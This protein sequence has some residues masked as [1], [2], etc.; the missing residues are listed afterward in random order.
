MTPR[1]KLL[2]GD[3]AV[4]RGAWEAGV[5]V[6]AAY[7][8][9]PSTEILENIARYDGIYAEW[10]PNEK[11][12]LEVAGNA[13]IAGVR[14]L[15]AMKHV[16]LNVASDP[17]MTL[18]YTGIGRGFVVACADDPGMHSSQNEQD[19]R[20]Y[21]RFA[22]VPM[23]EPGDSDEAL[24]MTKAAFELSE[25]FDTPVLLRMTTRVCHGKSPVT[26]GERAEVETK[27]FV[28]NPQKYVMI[29]GH[30]RKRHVI[31]EERA[32]KLAE[33]SE[34]S[35]FNRAIEGTNGIGI[36]TSGIAAQYAREVMPDAGFLILGMTWPLP[37]RM[38]RE[39][40]A[41][42][43]TLYV[44]EELEPYLEEQIRAM[45]I[46]VTGKEKF[47]RCGE[48]TPDLVRTGLTGTKPA[49]SR[50]PKDL[51]IPMRPPVLCPGCPHRGFFHIVNKNKLHV[52]GDVGCYTLSVLPPLSA[53]DTCICMGASISGAIGFAKAFEDQPGKK[54]VAALGDSTFMHSGLTGLMDT[55]YNKANVITCV[56]DNR[57]TAMT[58]HQE[59][60]GTGFT[61][62]GEP[63]HRTDIAEV[64]RAL[65]VKHVYE[66]DPYDLAETDRIMKT[67]LEAEGP[68]VIVVKRACA[69]KVRDPGFAKT[70]V[71]QDVCKKCG[72]CLKVGCP[73]II[74]KDDVYLVDRTMCYGCGICRQVCPFGAMVAIDDQG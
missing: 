47:P 12:A 15:A 1:T 52:A 27:P 30:A 33:V 72:S 36:I 6:A 60:P 57:T 53:M 70:T 37:E 23:F 44:I 16:G 56:L 17:F 9:T 54:V 10:S 34:T 3:E 39:F 19:N 65:G 69:L 68:A 11:V 35:P 66:A 63:T 4:A 51:P 22:K 61:I 43:E 71:L 14:A 13:A 25:A 41:R 67:C 73:A 49:P 45:G 20:A 26:P 5:K 7:P 40:S 62:K 2:T 59:H 48:L 38:I 28:R 29:P 64:A 18:A 21:A 50:I 42:Y 55:V 32:L 58:G 24:R 46:A 74:K 31:V 8:G